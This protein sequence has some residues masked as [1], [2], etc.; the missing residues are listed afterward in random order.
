MLPTTHNQTSHPASELAAGLT[1]I[2]L[3]VLRKAG[4]DGDSVELELELWRALTAGLER[5]ALLGSRPVAVGSLLDSTLAQVVHR[6]ALDVAVSFVADGAPSELE[7]RIRRWVGLPRI[8]QGSLGGLREAAA[9]LFGPKEGAVRPLGAS[10]IFR[11]L[12]VAALN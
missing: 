1:D 6:A 4:V 5:E 10:G 12:Q 3:E 7:A 9:K 2:A 11:K 8:P